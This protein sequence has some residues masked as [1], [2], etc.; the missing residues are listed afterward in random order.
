MEAKHVTFWLLLVA[1]AIVLL[2]A[3]VQGTVGFGMNLVAAP[4]LAIIDP[5]LVPVP[6]LLVASVFAVLAMLR[7]RGELDW[8]GVSWG[9]VGRVPGT[10]LGVAALALLPPRGLGILIGVAVLV[11]V[12]L[13]L[14]SWSPRPT[15]PALVTAGVA[16]GTFGTAAALGGPPIALIYQHVHG[17]KVRPTLGAYFAIGSLL[18]IV[19][20]S[21]GGQ[22]GPE[23]LLA[24]LVLFPFA[25]VGFA[26]SGPLRGVLDAGRTRPA[27]LMVATVG[28]VVLLL[29]AAM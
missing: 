29:Q 19:G 23:S 8:H 1:G 6:L 22:L 9:V 11:S 24:A 14:L 17:T 18:S 27:L 2:G 10:A 25:L 20:L 28:A 7:E 13:S 3:L 5:V 26:L 15:R 4:L 12:G 21:L 16:S